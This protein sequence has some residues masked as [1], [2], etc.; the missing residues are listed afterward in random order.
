MYSF[1]AFLNMLSTSLLNL[2]HTLNIELQL[3]TVLI[4]L[5]IVLYIMIDMIGK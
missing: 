3:T 2:L 4:L 5:A 1:L